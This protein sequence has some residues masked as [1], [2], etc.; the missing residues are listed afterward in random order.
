MSTAISEVKAK[1]AEA[2]KLEKE[3]RE[4]RVKSAMEKINS[5]LRENR[6]RLA[7]IPQISQDGRLVASVVIEAIEDTEAL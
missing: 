2:K 5:A 4:A 3:D 1:L 7:A 6:C